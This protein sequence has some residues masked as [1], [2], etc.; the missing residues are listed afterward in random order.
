MNRRTIAS[1]LFLVLNSSAVTGCVLDDDTGDEWPASLDEQPES[2]EQ[3]GATQQ[4]LGQRCEGVIIEVTNQREE[5]NGARPAIKV[6]SLEFYNRRTGWHTELVP[7]EVIDYNDSFPFVENLQN[8]D[9]DY[10]DSWIVNFKYDLGNGWSSEVDDFIDTPAV[11]C[12]DGMGV[13]LTVIEN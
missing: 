7:N 10:I 6:L 2:G 13:D 11:R 8:S 12:S 1:I 3:I 9:G 4:A 5:A